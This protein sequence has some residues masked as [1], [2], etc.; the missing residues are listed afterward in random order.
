MNYVVVEKLLH[1]PSICLYSFVK[2]LLQI[3]TSPRSIVVRVLALEEG[4]PLW[5]NQET[6]SSILMEKRGSFYI[7]FFIYFL[8]FGIHKEFYGGRK[9]TGERYFEIAEYKEGSFLMFSLFF[10]FDKMI[11]FGNFPSMSFQML[12]Y[13][14]VGKMM[15]S[16]WLADLPTF[17]F[18][19][20]LC[21]QPPNLI[22]IDGKWISEHWLRLIAALKNRTYLFIFEISLHVLF[23]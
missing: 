12:F 5:I 6:I 2:F 9:T 14:D 4:N 20:L 3:S 8:F 13:L 22:E 15:Q 21:R 1:L 11:C 19:L 7:K 17:W 23:L 10:F 16:R 18:F